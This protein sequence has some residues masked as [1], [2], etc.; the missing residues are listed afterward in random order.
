MR[1]T[2]LEQIFL[3]EKCFYPEACFLAFTLFF[4]L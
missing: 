1:Y 2:L 3:K 4:L